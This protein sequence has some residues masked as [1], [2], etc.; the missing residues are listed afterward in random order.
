M[1]R[2]T[3]T[4]INGLDTAAL[5][6]LVELLEQNAGGGQ[7]TFTTDSHWQDGA[8]V[9]TRMAGYRIDGE[10]VH[11]D[12]RRF[13]Q[14]CDEPTELSGTDAAPGRYAQKLVTPDQA[15]V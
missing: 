6:G 11:A 3:Q 12:E 7:V 13:V 10:T 4:T 14:L 2:T 15:A 9:L 1:T 5:G 8:R